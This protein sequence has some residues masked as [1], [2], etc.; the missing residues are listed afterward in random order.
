MVV[1]SVFLLSHTLKMWNVTQH[2]TQSPSL[3]RLSNFCFSEEKEMTERLSPLLI[4]LLWSLWLKMKGRDEQ[5]L[6][7]SDS[8]RVKDHVQDRCLWSEHQPG[9]WVTV[10]QHNLWNFLCCLCVLTHDN[11]FVYWPRP[12]DLLTSFSYHP[13]VLFITISHWTFPVE[14]GISTISLYISDKRWKTFKN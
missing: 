14:S 5:W 7:G 4:W 11:L 10:S 12:P 13:I 9:S 1:F 3:W 6:S 8:C 2:K